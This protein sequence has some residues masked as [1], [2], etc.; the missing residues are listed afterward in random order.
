MVSPV[1]EKFVIVAG[2]LLCLAGLAYL[3]MEFPTQAAFYVAAAVAGT[4]VV[5]G[6]VRYFTRTPV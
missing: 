6:L 4:I 2:G 1:F 3:F 5:G